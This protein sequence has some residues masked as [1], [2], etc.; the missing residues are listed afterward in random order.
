[1]VLLFFAELSGDSF[2]SVSSL[3]TSF[4]SSPASTLP[5]HQRKTYQ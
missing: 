5:N 3:K 4:L 1:V 2:A